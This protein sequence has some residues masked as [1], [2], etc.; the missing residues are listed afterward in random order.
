MKQLLTIISDWKKADYYIGAFRGYVLSQFPDSS[1]VEL[2][3][4]VDSFKIEQAAFILKSCYFRFPPNT[5]HIIA[6]YSEPDKESNYFIARYKEQFFIFPDNGFFTLFWTDDNPDFVYKLSE[7]IET[8]FPEIDI[9]ANTACK[10]LQGAEPESLGEP[11]DI[12]AK[13]FF[14][15]PSFEPGVITG[16]ILFVDSFGNAITNITKEYF[17]RIVGDKKF[18]IIP[19]NTYYPIKK[20]SK[21]YR[22]VPQGNH[23]AVFNSNNYLEIA[24][25]N[26]SAYE[27]LALKEG[28]N[29]RIEIY[30]T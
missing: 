22:E 23:V 1:I 3:N 16:T 24:I 21:Y 17:E 5:I 20:I 30:D 6:V 2:S 9:M 4:N 10:I 7:N 15:C 29:I 25:R 27:L 8:T 13:K 18:Q 28:L 26:G 11:Y 19:N 14:A 12:F